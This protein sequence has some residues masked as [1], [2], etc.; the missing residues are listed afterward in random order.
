MN[1]VEGTLTILS[2]Q[3]VAYNTKKFLFSVESPTPFSFVAGQFLSLQFGST[4]WR[5]YSIASTP[6]DH[7]IE[8]IIKFVEG[9]TASTIWW[10]AKVGDKF[11]F[12]GPFGGFQ[13]SKN[14][15]A[16]LVFCATG[17]GIAPIRSMIL[18][19]NKKSKPRSM[20]LLYGGK[21]IDNLAYIDE[22]SGWDTRLQVKLGL[23]Q[24][25]ELKLRDFGI[26]TQVQNCRITKFLEERT[27]SPN[28]EFYICGNGDMVK[29]VSELLQ[30]MGVNKS[31]IFME[32]F[33]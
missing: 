2:I 32:R 33:N 21:S 20:E 14:L 4:V 22:L 7:P 1:I 24:K 27:Y 5:A 19:E 28:D 13:L 15:D 16:H 8:F 30:T 29:S 10:N 17:T 23:S 12:K 26:Q 9:G 6:E 31:K 3:E 25:I 18:V 11:H